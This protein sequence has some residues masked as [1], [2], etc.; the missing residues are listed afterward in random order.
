MNTDA[1]VLGSGADELVAAHLLARAGRRVL[2]VDAGDVNEAPMENAWVPQVVIRDLALQNHGLELQAA[3]PWA[4]AP[5]PG[6]ERLQLFHDMARSV[7]SIR[8]VSARDAANW[9]EFCER[10][11]RLAQL[12]EGIYAAAPPD[13][14]SG[15][16][17]DL[18][19]LGAL[20]WR[21]RRLGRQGME[22]LLRLLPM[23]AA[24]LLDDWFENDALKGLLGAHAVMHLC[25]GPRSGGTVFPL[26][27]HHV[28]NLRGVFR[29]PRT[30]VRRVLA[31]LPGI[32]LRHGVDAQ[33]LIVHSGAVAGVALASGEEITSPLVVSGLGPKRTLL[34]L[35]DPGWLDPAL[36]QAV[37]NVRARGVVA[38]IALT[39]ESAPAFSSLV[40]APSLDYVEQAY[41]DAK[42]RRVSQA[43]FMIASATRPDGA[44]PHRIEIHFQYAPHALEEGEWNA[45]RRESLARRALEILS[46]HEPSLKSAHIEG[47]QSPLDLQ[48]AQGWPEGQAHH[49]ELALD[50]LL[51]M[52]PVPQLARYRTPIP[53]LYLCGPSMHPGGGI[54]GAAG[55]NCAREI[56]S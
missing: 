23:P 21:T 51:W 33:K 5:L 3:D 13:P 54:A 34:A 44:N 39:A 55:R 2:V 35:L 32:E 36:A 40:I 41:D 24:D 11:A 10:M 37:A 47:V 12:L 8:R 1:I 26:L 9:P 14:M 27:H 43:P 49:A 17:K 29:P 38:R 16:W 56:L 31:R 4:E 46:R 28:G 6:G 42:Y 53:G 50:Q 48:E 15:E 19:Q 25:H 7:E 18:A 20:A 30:N 22:D 52:R 45:A